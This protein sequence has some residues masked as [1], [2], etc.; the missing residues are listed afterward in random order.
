MIRRLV[1]VLRDDGLGRVISRLLARMTVVGARLFVAPER[2]GASYRRIV[3]DLVV[4]AGIVADHGIAGSDRR[5]LA[6]TN[7]SERAPDIAVRA[8]TAFEQEAAVPFLGKPE[9][10]PDGIMIP[11]LARPL[12]HDAHDVAMG[13][14]R[15]ALQVSE[16]QIGRGPR[17]QPFGA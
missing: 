7:I 2:N 17:W 3:V 15:W 16:T 4:M 5:R 1:V 9:V 10:E 13:R 11:I 6:A 12:V 8:A 14:Q